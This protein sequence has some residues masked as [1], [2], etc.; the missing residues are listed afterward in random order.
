MNAFDPTKPTCVIGERC[1][2]WGYAAIFNIPD[3]D[4]DIFAPG[5][6]AST[7]AAGPSSVEFLN[8]HQ[9]GAV[10]GRWLQFIEDSAGLYVA[11]EFFARPEGILFGMGLSVGPANGKGQ[12]LT[13]RGK[14]IRSTDPLTEISAVVEPRH[15][16]AC[17]QGG[18]PIHVPYPGS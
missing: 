10:I 15:P 18:W 1:V 9:A 14:L 13:P 16:A 4:G 12:L 3:C 11:G 2:F 7:V 17:I 8:G 6:F 5:V